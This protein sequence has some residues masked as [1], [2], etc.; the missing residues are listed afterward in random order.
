MHCRLPA[1]RGDRWFRS[2]G[3]Q[4]PVPGRR[5]VAHNPRTFSFRMSA[6]VWRRSSNERPFSEMLVIRSRT[7]RVRTGVSFSHPL[8]VAND[9][10]R[11]A[12]RSMEPAP[13]CYLNHACEPNCELLSLHED[14][15][16]PPEDCTIVLEASATCSPMRTSPATPHER[17]SVW[18]WQPKLPRLG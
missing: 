2:D 7:S 14:D 8:D 1:C 13:W 11:I 10:F 15:D 4:A 9:A 12:C 5:P 3:D 18:V 17:N 6:A 16:C